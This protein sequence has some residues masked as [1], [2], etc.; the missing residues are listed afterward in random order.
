MNSGTPVLLPSSR[1]GLPALDVALRVV[2]EAG[3]TLVT[4]LHGEKEVSYKGRANLV[5]DVDKLV[6]RQVIEE[7][8]GEFPDDGFLAEESDAVPTNSEYTWII[9]P[10]DGTRNYVLGIPFFCTVLALAKG[11]DVIMGLT[12]DPVRDEMFQAVK[13]GG[14]FL[15]GSAITV[16]AKTELEDAL[17]SYDLGYV[18]E[19]A[20]TAIELVLHLW[21]NIQGTRIMGSAALGLAYAAC[22]RTDMYFHHNLCPWDIAT[23]LVLVPEAGGVITDKYKT[24]SSLQ[25]E[26]V[27]A[28]GNTLHARFL[29]ATEG[30]A[31]RQ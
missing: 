23:G 10:L 20:S 26:S 30:L 3:Q 2:K 1:S 17:L 29:K 5:S 16:S 22:G 12:Y 15:N 24:P 6:E 9:D 21:P 31:W 7:L 14:A 19:E 8:H 11:N 13:G 25:A 28:S 18:D 27:I 4:R